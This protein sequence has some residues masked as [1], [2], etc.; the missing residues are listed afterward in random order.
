MAPSRALVRARYQYEV[1]GNQRTVDNF[2]G[3][4]EDMNVGYYVIT[5][6]LLQVHVRFLVCM[7]LHKTACTMISA[8]RHPTYLYHLEDF[9][10]STFTCS[11]HGQTWTSRS[12]PARRDRAEWYIQS[13]C[14]YDMITLLAVPT[15]FQRRGS[16]HLSATVIRSTRPLSSPPAAPR[17][18]SAP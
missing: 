8:C 12:R 6:L 1:L 2:S 10:L 11:A 5:G 15:F 16:P 4:G 17:R 9:I 14:M 7:Y 18:R 3:Q 13:T